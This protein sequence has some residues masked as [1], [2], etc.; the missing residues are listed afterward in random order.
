MEIE[1]RQ[2]ENPM[3]WLPTPLGDI[4]GMKELVEILRIMNTIQ[5]G[6]HL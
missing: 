5:R 4:H 2:L 3:F 6:N 1:F